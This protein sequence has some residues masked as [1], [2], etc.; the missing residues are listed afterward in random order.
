MA[1][2]NSSVRLPSD[3]R[4][5]AARAPEA[6]HISR[7]QAAQDEPPA[8]A[9]SLPISTEDKTV[10]S[11]RP[12]LSEAAAAKLTT[13]QHLGNTLVGKRRDRVYRPE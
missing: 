13:P 2:G 7:T 10:I 6:T 3:E 8:L 5:E 12:P 11:K 4:D 1:P 9:T